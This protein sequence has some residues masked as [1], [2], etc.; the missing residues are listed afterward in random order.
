MFITSL[1]PCAL[2]IQKNSLAKLI[3]VRVILPYVGDLQTNCYLIFSE[4]EMIVI[5]PGGSVEKIIK[6]IKNIGITPKAIINTHSHYDHV[7]GNKELEGITG[8]K[9]IKDLKE[10]DIIN[11]GKDS[12]KVIK[13][14]GHTED[15][16]CLF[17]DDFLISG[18]VLFSRGGYGRTDL[19]SGSEEKMRKTIKRL[20]EKFSDDVTVYPG[21]GESFKMEEWKDFYSY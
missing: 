21:H 20:K 3:G 5:D 10:G 13:T 19:P 1:N 9:V 7:L 15:S 2:N 4:E 6:E 8:A 14:P 16:I 18:D 12:L 17:E 11:I